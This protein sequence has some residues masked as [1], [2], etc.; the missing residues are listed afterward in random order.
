[1]LLNFSKNNEVEKK[2]RWITQLMSEGIDNIRK[3]V[4]SLLGECML[5]MRIELMHIILLLG[6]GEDQHFT[7]INDNYY[8]QEDLEK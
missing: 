7:K 8:V 5:A 1:M 4:I 3:L 2:L 6:I